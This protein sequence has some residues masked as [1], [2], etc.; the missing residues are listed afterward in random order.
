MKRLLILLL[1]VLSVTV[2]AQEKQVA[3]LEPIPMTKEVSTMHRSMV[4]GEM[5]KAIGRQSGY[6]A[7]TR[8]DIDQIMSEQN[9]QQSGMV[10]D[11]TR[12]RIGA[13][14]GVDYV[15]VTRITKEG[16]NYYLEANLVNIETG[17]ILNPATQYCELE[18]GSL[19]NMLA[20]CEK[21]AAELVGAQSVAYNATTS[22]H[23]YASSTTSQAIQTRVQSSP[24]VIQWAHYDN[25]QIVNYLIEKKY[26][27]IEIDE[28]ILQQI[29][30]KIQIILQ[31]VGL[32]MRVKY[33]FDRKYLLYVD[34]NKAVDVTPLIKDRL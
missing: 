31:Q 10:D 15:C 14:Q 22:P 32:E 1:S 6:A 23:S 28:Q 17:K 20:A 3:I 27:D 2:F 24:S 7:F 11:A 8:T 33:I 29:N 13:M 26:K 12:K 4:R 9:F 16:N 18:G 5:V 19:S 30:R 34:E 21:L 25:D